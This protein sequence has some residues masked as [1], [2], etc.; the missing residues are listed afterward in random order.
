MLDEA[1]GYARGPSA[2]DPVPADEAQRDFPAILGVCAHFGKENHLR[3]FET[4][5]D[6]LLDWVDGIL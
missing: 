3:F 6:V 5:L 1:L 4:G 2:A